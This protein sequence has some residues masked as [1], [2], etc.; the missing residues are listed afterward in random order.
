FA[1]ALYPDGSPAQCE[2]NLWQGQKAQGKPL[3]TVKTNEAGLA[4]FRLTPET[5]QFR[6]GNYGQRQVEMI[7]AQGLQ[8]RMMGA[9]HALVDLYAE[10]KYAKGNSAKTPTALT[11]EPLGENVLLRLDKA[12]YKGGESLKVDVHTS[13]GLPTVSPDVIKAGQPMLTKWLDV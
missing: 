6:Q 11:S 2:V 13:A 5:K 7:S 1:A 9:P 8:G 10:A 3:A 12:V 4:E